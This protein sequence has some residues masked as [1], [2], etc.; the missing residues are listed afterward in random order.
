MAVKLIAL[1]N[2]TKTS[3]YAIFN[4]EELVESGIFTVK[5]D[6]EER[7]IAMK[8]KIID[9]CKEK[10]VTCLIMEQEQIH[11]GGA[12][13]NALCKL[14]GVT[15]SV[16]DDLQLAYVIIPIN[17]WRLDCGIKHNMKRDLQKAEAIKKV[18][19]LYGVETKSDDEAEA[20]LIGRFA[21]KN[22]LFVDKEK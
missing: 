16:T 11:K 13:T 6:L 20:I 3:G 8:H 21:V 17:T 7:L 10:D 5:G 9:K 14:Q 22:K 15:L 18:K 12:V 1:D 19:E 2:A 4:G